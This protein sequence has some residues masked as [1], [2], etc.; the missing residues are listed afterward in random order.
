[1]T[2]E[3]LIRRLQSH[4]DARLA[5]V[6]PPERLAAQVMAIPDAHPV[7]APRRRPGWFSRPL[8]LA[9]AAALLL[10]AALAAA[11]FGGALPKPFQPSVDLGIFGPISGWVVYGGDG[12]IWGDNPDGPDVKLA[13]GA[14]TPL[15]WSRDGT[16]LLLRRQGLVVLN[17]DGSETRLTR[18][19][20]TDSQY[21]RTAAIS[22]DGSLVVFAT[23]DGS[24]NTGAVY[25]VDADG[26]SPEVLLVHDG[27]E[28]VTFSPDGTQ[29]A[30]LS[31]RG[32]SSHRVSVMNADGSN[33]HEIVA[34]DVTL[35]PGHD[36]GLA[37]SP[38]GDRIAL[39][40][41]GNFYTFA[42]DGSGF[43][44]ARWLAGRVEPFWSADGSEFETT[45]PRHP[46]VP[47][48]NGPA[49]SP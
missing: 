35:R 21:V 27:L 48:S 24:G 4:F 16:R 40:I 12:G 46:G 20:L 32:D 47:A 11:L 37:W 33:V 6:F 1:M 45:G 30:Y 14:G 3:H 29:I 44:V 34:N 13:A 23:I 8:G 10:A 7:P 42:P 17:A 15:A 39:G 36:H 49:Q 19:W 9:F 2:D 18:D 31:G 25:S 43:T 41:E 22:P 28:G 5:D 26:G 38:A